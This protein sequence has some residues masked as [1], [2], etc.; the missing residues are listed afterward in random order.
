MSIDRL[1]RP[2]TTKSPKSL[3]KNKTDG[4][5]LS[6]NAGENTAQSETHKHNRA[7]LNGAA[8]IIA[9]ACLLAP[10]YSFATDSSGDLAAEVERLRKELGET[11]KENDQLKKAVS[12]SNVGT[13]ANAAPAQPVPAATTAVATAE[14]PKKEEKSFD[15]EPKNLSE[16]VVTS[17]RKE[18]KLQEV[19]IPIA[20]ISGEQMKRDNIVSVSD[21]ARRVPNLGVTATN[22]RQTSIALRGLGKNSGNES[23][24]AS[25][26]VMVDN[27]W[28]SWVGSTWTNYADIDHVEVL[29]GPQGTLQGKN[30]NLGLINVVTQ[31][32][33]F[34]SGYYVD[35]F[36]GNRDS[37]QGKA[38]ATG[39][40]LPGLLAYRAS[41][42]VD[43][44]DGS[45]ANLDAPKTDGR[46][47]E[48]N[49]M[50]GRLQFL[51]TP[52]DVLSARVI[53]DRATSSQTMS[54]GPLIDDRATF[55]DGRVRPITFS[56]RLG[57][58][59]FNSLKNSGQPLTVIGDPRKVA[60]N[61]RQVSR[62]D[63][64]GVSAE[65]NWDV[66]KHKITSVSAYRDALFEPHHDGDST[67]ADIQHISGWQIKNKQWS[68]ELRI[69]SQEPGPIDYQGGLFWM[70]SQAT[71]ENQRLYGTD[72][73]AF[74]ASDA[75][76]AA[77]NATA[78]GREQLRQS[79]DGVMK[80]GTR[81]PEVDSYAAYGQV[82]WHITKAATLT[83]GLRDTYEERY[84]QGTDGYVGGAAVTG[85]ALAIRN[86]ALG[87]NGV[88]WT[89]GKQGFSQNSQNWLV[90]PSYKITKD[91]MTYFSVSGG[92]KSGAAQFN[93][94]TG[95]IENVKPE[96]VM[97]YE[98]GVKSNWFNRQLAVNVNLYNTVVNGF[99]SQLSVIDP[100]TASGYRTTLG[101]IKEIQLQGVELET[102][103]NVTQGLNLF[104][105]GSFNH[106]VYN[107]FKD[108]PCPAELGLTTNCDQS[109]QTIPNAPQ[110][111]AN[112]GMDYKVPLGFGKFNDHGLQW[113]AFL[114]D[115][116]KSAANY[117]ASL[118][119]S[120]KQDAYHV[121]DGGI[122]IG[123]K[124]GQYNLDLVGRNIF[125]TIYLTNAGQISTQS[126]ASGTYGEARYYGVHFRAK[127]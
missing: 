102:N 10:D 57:R 36:G 104:L 52:S 47:Q 75:Q 116:Y 22:V 119:A 17:R 127:F 25:V 9:G 78:A 87:N 77:L 20:V 53:V 99:Q 41:F 107:D 24:E 114:V 35:G 73:G 39:T 67:T 48:T 66:L 120:G 16:V 44:R 89:Q 70:H 59:W 83:L 43:R 80:T 65:I 103:W 23:M 50:G 81:N 82:N 31:T 28:S 3:K 15:D 110:F 6:A 97:D 126:A 118:S 61:D 60:E 122:G 98:L 125:D 34:K 12:N 40:V 105:N 84:N 106:A 2:A 11:K 29:R 72:A 46:L 18:E 37:L 90:N 108:A 95:A 92:Q 86:S 93:D 56:S 38:G 112:Y 21:F 30:S 19:P 74:Y 14:P 109:G 111:T 68:Q 94:T 5:S 27:V 62:G 7:A 76:F 91:L 121:T 1:G 117:N 96:D 79:L 115:S 13:A 63:Q 58:D 49:A 71:A 4:R 64:Q 88:K 51:L 124:N 123:T 8:M 55:T 32:P 42:Y 69:A 85:T 54:V 100:G 101:N 113:H 26:G 33:S 45:I